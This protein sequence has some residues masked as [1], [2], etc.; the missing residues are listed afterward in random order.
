MER[1]MQ[2]CRGEGACAAR[3]ARAILQQQ[4][5]AS[6]QPRPSE[7]FF[8]AARPSPG[9]QVPNWSCNLELL[10]S[11]Q[12]FAPLL[13]ADLKISTEGHPTADDFFWL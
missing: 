1:R 7:Q 9:A 13:T 4:T 12:N 11:S 8:R 2:R 5:R 3:C 6:T 10:N